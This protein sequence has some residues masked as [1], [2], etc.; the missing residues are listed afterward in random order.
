MSVFRYSFFK[1]LNC[2][3]EDALFFFKL[4]QRCDAIRWIHINMFFWWRWEWDSY[5][6]ANV[7]LYITVFSKTVL[8]K[9]LSNRP[10]N[11]W[12]T[13]DNKIKIRYGTKYQSNSVICYPKKQKT[14]EKIKSVIINNNSIPENLQ[15]NKKIWTT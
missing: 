14:K 3:L 9:K 1:K 13:L 2:N 6:L 7:L 4:P 10:D 12:R 11:K 5:H 8:K 15:E